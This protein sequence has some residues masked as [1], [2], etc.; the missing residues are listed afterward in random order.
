M[1]K[2][3][4]PVK[5]CADCFGSSGNPRIR[6]DGE[7]VLVATCDKCYLVKCQHLLLH[8]YDG[9]KDA[10]KKICLECA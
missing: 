10:Q 4:D 6:R 3:D 1:S 7:Y 8:D 9:K 5:L 2:D